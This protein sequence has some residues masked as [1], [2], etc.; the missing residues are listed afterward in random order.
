M[1][2]LCFRVTITL[3]VC[4]HQVQLHSCRTHT[5][6]HSLV[7]LQ[8]IQLLEAGHTLCAKVVSLFGQFSPA[9][10]RLGCPQLLHLGLQVLHVGLKTVD[11]F[12]Q[13]ERGQ[14]FEVVRITELCGENL[15]KTL[16]LS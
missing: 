9:P 5:C 15:A 10:V 7:F 13:A 8:V 14:A 11:R 16:P 3:A 12:C 2:W 1:E 6:T 4:W